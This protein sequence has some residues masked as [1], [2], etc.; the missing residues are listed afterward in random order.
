M[1]GQGRYQVPW[2]TPRGQEASLRRHRGPSS[3]AAH[4]PSPNVLVTLPREEGFARRLECR[5][6]LRS[7]DS[8][9]ERGRVSGPRGRRPSAP[10]AR[11]SGHRPRV[12]SQ[13]AAPAGLGVAGHLTNVDRRALTPLFWS[14][15]NR[16]ALPAGQG[17]SARR[18]RGRAAPHAGAGDLTDVVGEVAGLAAQNVSDARRRGGRCGR[19]DLGEQRVKWGWWCG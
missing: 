15:G 19:R 4:D 12:A 2:Y 11:G 17:A 5:N 16:M 7:T 18:W 8:N 6:W 13:R 3:T 9:R 10:G 1:T 14:N